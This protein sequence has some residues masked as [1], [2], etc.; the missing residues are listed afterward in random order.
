M[1]K[2]IQRVAVAA[3]KSIGIEFGGVDILF[4]DNGE[5]YISEVNSPCA[6]NHTQTLT[7]IDI[8][9]AIVDYLIN[10]SN[11]KSN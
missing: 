1:K 4:S 11:L 10:K 2:E 5:Y 9:G 6:Y 8:A 7:G 3:V